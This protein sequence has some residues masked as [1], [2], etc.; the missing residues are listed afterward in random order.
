VLF[1][2]PWHGRVLLGTT[3]TA[4]KQRPLE[5]HPQEKEID[6]LLKYAARY[7]VDPPK[8]NDVL[9][10]FAGLRPLVKVNHK[11]T[12]AL[13]RDHMILLSPSGLITIAG[14]KWTTYRKM[15]ED[16]INKAIVVGGLTERP[17]QTLHLQLHGWLPSHAQELHVRQEPSYGSDNHAIEQLI[18]SSPDLG[19]PLHDRLPYLRAH[20]V[21]AAKHEMALCLE[22]VLSRRI[23]ALLLDAQA[24]LEAAPL[25]AHIMAKELKE[26]KQWEEEQVKQYKQLAAHYLPR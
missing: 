8:R 22:D 13:S 6:F 24:S 20:V 21:W 25:A 1:F 4:V 14:G 16:V 10:M 2:V 11:T 3:D 17:C 12:A 5:P 7:L 23:R 19:K 26:T 15:A 18:R 9:S